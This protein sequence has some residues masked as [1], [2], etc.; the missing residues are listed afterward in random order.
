[1]TK[2]PSGDQVSLRKK[3]VTVSSTNKFRRWCGRDWSFEFKAALEGLSPTLA[4]LYSAF[5]GKEEAMSRTAIGTP[6][7]P[8]TLKSKALS[9]IAADSKTAH[10]VE[11]E[12]VQLWVIPAP[13]FLSSEFPVFMRGE[14]DATPKLLSVS[15]FSAEKPHTGLSQT[16]A[17]DTTQD[18]ITSQHLAVKPDDL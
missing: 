13:S 3:L 12:R 9:G 14:C 11:S 6:V 5:R 4:F 18:L 10:R 7:S 17:V 16:S 8:S 15:P 1:M 2:A